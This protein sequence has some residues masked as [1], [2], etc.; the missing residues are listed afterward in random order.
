MKAIN[1]TMRILLTT[2][3]GISLLACIK[4]PP[5]ALFTVD[6]VS[7][8]SPL[9][10]TFTNT[11]TFAESY[12]WDFGDGSTSNEENPVHTFNYSYENE[13]ADF[14]VTLEATNKKQKSSSFTET[15]TANKYI[16][17]NNPKVTELDIMVDT[18]VMNWYDNAL[19]SAMSIALIDGE[20]VNI[21]HYGETD[22][23]NNKLPDDNTLYEIAS[24][25]KTFTGIAAIH[26][27]NANS[28]SL[29]DPVK[30]YLPAK[31]APGLSKDGVDVT[32]RHILNHTSGLPF[33][34]YNLTVNFDSTA[35]YNHLEQRG[36]GMTPGTLP[37]NEDAYWDSH[38]STFSFG[39]LGTLLERNK[40]QS[41]QNIFKETILNPFGMSLTTLYDVQ[42]LS[43]VAY[44]HTNTG[45]IFMAP[46][47][48]T[49]LYGGGWLKS[50][51]NDMVKYAKG[52]M[53][54]DANTDLGMAIIKSFED[55]YELSSLG[56]NLAFS[57]GLPW[58][59]HFIANSSKIT[60]HTGAGPGCRTIFSVDLENQK[61]IIILSSSNTSNENPLPFKAFGLWQY[62]FSQ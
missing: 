46:A 13:Q 31:T 16:Q 62:Y 61:A 45:E 60:T 10:V 20:E 29:D 59:H 26:W 7:G 41:L 35:T 9:T 50:N 44:S 17:S 22:Y 24:V 8:N 12:H 27:L 40:Q 28:I 33:D 38:Y 48:M 14:T 49:G 32:F 15:I 57:Q 1:Y 5:E 3:L 2:L 43:N 37:I 11:S 51:I 6:S 36:L 55:Q 30:D 58:H 54:A 19:M 23:G 47:T 4:E 18:A 52:I 21:F 53:N 42:S 25:T 56:F 39:L 34:P